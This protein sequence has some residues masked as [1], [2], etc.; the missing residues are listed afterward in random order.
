[1]WIT[2]FNKEEIEFSLREKSNSIQLFKN[3]KNLK[4]I[5]K[6]DDGYHVFCIMI[7]IIENKCK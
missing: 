3:T 7:Y 5:R 6:I 2:H 1:M 4:S